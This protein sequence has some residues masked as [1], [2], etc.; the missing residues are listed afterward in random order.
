M[1]YRKIHIIGGGTVAHV[2][3]HLALSAPAYGAT[4][5]DLYD[6]ITCSEKVGS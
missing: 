6:A 2:R 5:R 3:P 4:V 1:S